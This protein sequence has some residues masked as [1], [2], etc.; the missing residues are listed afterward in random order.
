MKRENKVKRD[1]LLVGY[2]STH[3]GE[4]NSANYNEII[5]YLRQYGFTLTHDNL[6]K[7]ITKIKLERCLPIIY[8][9]G[10]GYFLANNKQELLN[11]IKDLKSMQ[12]ALQKQIDLLQKFMIDN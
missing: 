2:I 8:K 9:R 5:Q 10:K 11:T 12:Y 7:L 4:D 3:I 1:N 6:R